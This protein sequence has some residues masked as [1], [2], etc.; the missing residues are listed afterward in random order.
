MVIIFI[1]LTGT[2]ATSALAQRNTGTSERGG[3]YGSPGMAGASGNTYSGRDASSISGGFNPPA[4]GQSVSVPDTT[5]GN[6][7]DTSGG[8]RPE[9]G[10]NPGGNRPNAGGQ[11]GESPAI[12]QQN[13]ER[14]A[15]SFG[16]NGERPSFS[17]SGEGG[18][19]AG[20]GESGFAPQFNFSRGEGQTWQGF[21]GFGS[22]V[23]NN[24]APTGAPGNIDSSQWNPPSDTSQIPAAPASMDEIDSV[25]AVQ[26]EARGNAVEQTQNAAQQTYDQFWTDYYTAVDSAADVYYQTV[27]ASVDYA[28]QAY[29]EA[30]NYTVQTVDYYVDYATEYEQYC[31]YYSWDCY[32]YT[33]DENSGTYVNIEYVSD[34]PV[35]TFTI[36][37]VNVNWSDVPVEP[38]SSAEA[39]EA[40]VVFASEQLGMVVQ[41]LYAGDATQEIQQI[42][43]FLPPEAEAYAALL[44]GVDPAYWGILNGGVGV[45]GTLDCSSGC[46]GQDIPAEL[47]AASAG[48]YMLTVTHPM[49]ADSSAALDLITTV[50]PAFNGLAFAQIE[51]V[52][53]G[54][55]FMATTY[56]IGADASGQGTS[57]PK[58]V[59]AGVMQINNQTVVY[60]LVAVGE[61]QVTA[62][63][64]Q[65]QP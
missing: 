31:F 24:D 54:M 2:V 63:F 65:F 59:Y 62:F 15:F 51:N 22:D 61:V 5:G 28:Q 56:G 14:P 3:S 29:Y 35:A 9:G 41:P 57:V 8:N 53:S 47:S 46:S 64:N 37:E 33:Y 6:R 55:A 30:L 48:V 23:E 27:T 50:Y 1:F 12:G 43:T 40:I 34:E 25:I 49:P 17:L 16:Q 52:E 13:G 26:Q 7:P 38:T 18:F 60:G 58:V 42:M 21:G 44:S 39:Y 19:L 10:A 20:R 32:S 36:E 4:T 45:V 11:N